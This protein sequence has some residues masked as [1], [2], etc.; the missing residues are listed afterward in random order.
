MDFIKK[1]WP[2][3]FN[4]EDV[5]QL[6]IKAIIYVV[7]DIV[8]GTLIGLL[9]KIQIVGVIFSIAVSFPT[10]N[11]P[12]PF[13]QVIKNP[14]SPSLNLNTSFKYCISDLSCAKNNFVSDDVST[15]CASG[16]S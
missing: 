2:F 15:A 6:V 1:Y 16:F 14:A 13:P 11:K 10:F 8:L 5:K 3:S 7:I 12:S 9:A 4:T